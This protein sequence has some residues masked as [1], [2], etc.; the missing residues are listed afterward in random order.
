MTPNP[1]PEEIK[2]ARVTVGLTQEQ[3]GAIVHS[4]SRRAW[5]NWE[6]GESKIPMAEWELFLIKT[7]QKEVTKFVKHHDK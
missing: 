1:T 4:P 7:G 6:R 5:Q 2:M 3:A